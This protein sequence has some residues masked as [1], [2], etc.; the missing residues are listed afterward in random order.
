MKILKSILNLRMTLIFNVNDYVFDFLIVIGS[1]KNFELL[2]EIL[3]NAFKRQKFGWF[4]NLFDYLFQWF[5][6]SSSI[7]Y[8]KIRLSYL[9]KSDHPFWIQI[10]ESFIKCLKINQMF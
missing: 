5:D 4:S 6:K 9:V 10:N 7:T 1:A 8:N 3:L 2:T